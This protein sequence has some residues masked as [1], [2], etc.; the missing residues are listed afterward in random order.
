M[1][2]T[3]LRRM[4][5]CTVFIE[6]DAGAREAAEAMRWAADRID[7]LEEGLRIIAEPNVT[8]ATWPG[9]EAS[10]ARTY[11][12]YAERRNPRE[13]VLVRDHDVSGEHATWWAVRTMDGEYYLDENSLTWKECPQ[14]M[15]GWFLSI[16]SAGAARAK[17]ARLEGMRF[18]GLDLNP[19]YC[20]IARRRI[21][22]VAPLFGGAA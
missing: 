16:T 18:V 17:A 10:I 13:A 20:E 2:T 5:G 12:E 14:A 8:D 7:R 9:K 3:E 4:A 15:A 22:D 19:E 1:D 21:G 11:L 6:P